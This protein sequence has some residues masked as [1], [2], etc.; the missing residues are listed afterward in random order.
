MD[1][2]ICRDEYAAPCLHEGPLMVSARAAVDAAR[3]L[4][5][6]R[7]ATIVRPDFDRIEA[8]QRG[9]PFATD[10]YGVGENRYVFSKPD[11]GSTGPTEPSMHDNKPW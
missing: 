2:K 11:G 10:K 3:R 9:D 4:G 8:L 1:V 6:S 5:A 7:H